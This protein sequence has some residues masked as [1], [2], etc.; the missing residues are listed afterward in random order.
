MPTEN[1]QA[2]GITVR[3]LRAGIPQIR[4]VPTS[5]GAMI[6]PSERGPS[7]TAIRVDSFA[8]FERIFGSFVQHIGQCIPGTVDPA[9][10]LTL[11][12]PCCI[13]A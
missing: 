11:A 6:G 1:F 2:P 3:E 10:R 4:G 5:T 8:K 7:N 13:A 9:G 12:D